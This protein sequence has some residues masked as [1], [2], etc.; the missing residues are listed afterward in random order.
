MQNCGAR[1]HIHVGPG[2]ASPASFPN[3]EERTQTLFEQ[4]RLTANVCLK[5]LPVLDARIADCNNEI[6]ETKR[7]RGILGAEI[8]S[9]C[10]QQREEKELAFE[11]MNAI[12]VTSKQ[13]SSAGKKKE[14]LRIRGILDSIHSN[15]YQ[16]DLQQKAYENRLLNLKDR[17][18]S[19]ERQLARLE[20]Q[21]DL[22]NRTLKASLKWIRLESLR[23]GSKL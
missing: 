8:G 5:T 23:R 1:E 6:V 19:L 3:R 11:Q 14:R 10:R 20:E 21:K 22:Q 4:A 7:Q 18:G 17:L 15:A 2:Y 9:F 13:G 12:E 16:A